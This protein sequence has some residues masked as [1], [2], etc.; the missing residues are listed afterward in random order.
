METRT[1]AFFMNFSGLKVAPDIFHLKRERGGELE[2][3]LHKITKLIERI[4]DKKI[5]LEEALNDAAELERLFEQFHLR[6]IAELED[7][8]LKKLFE[9]LSVDDKTHRM[10][11]INVMK[12]FYRA[13]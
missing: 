5:G 10:R 11:L 9:A 12:R 7:A 4:R 1:I 8:S 3:G 2:T 13:S 6:T